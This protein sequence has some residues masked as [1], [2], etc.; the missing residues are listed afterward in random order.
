MQEMHS[1]LHVAIILLTIDLVTELSI[2]SNMSPCIH[3]LQL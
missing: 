1:V 3:G 2:S